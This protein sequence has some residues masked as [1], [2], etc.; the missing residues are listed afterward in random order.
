M[1]LILKF[2]PQEDRLRGALWKP[3]G[4]CHSSSLK[5]GLPFCP[6]ETTALPAPHYAPPPLP[7][8][9]ALSKSSPS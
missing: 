9:T 6:D 5:A 3:W 4:G 1:V 7:L 2:C 8:N